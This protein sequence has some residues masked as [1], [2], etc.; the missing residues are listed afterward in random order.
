MGSRQDLLEVSFPPF[1]NGFETVLLK[2]EF[3]AALSGGVAAY[4]VD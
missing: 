2:R 4:W 3:P 1:C